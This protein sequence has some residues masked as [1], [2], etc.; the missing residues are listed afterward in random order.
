MRRNQSAKKRENHS[1]RQNYGSGLNDSYDYMHMCRGFQTA[2]K[3][4]I[5]L[6]TYIKLLGGKN[7]K[8]TS[9]HPEDLQDS[10]G[11]GLCPSSQTGCGLSW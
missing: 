4:C 3:T 10:L 2:F 8:L 9:I 5:T 6:N 7:T 11:L 1:T